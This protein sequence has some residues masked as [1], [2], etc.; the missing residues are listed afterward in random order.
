MPTPFT[1]HTA[2]VVLDIDETAGGSSVKTSAGQLYGITAGNS[3]AA[4]VYLKVVDVT[5][6][7]VGTTVPI[8]T[9][10]IPTNES[11]SVSFPGGI[12]F[13]TGIMTF[14]TVT[15]AVAAQDAPGANDC[16]AT[17]IFN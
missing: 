6:A 2:L 10:F 16:H 14:A 5:T 3:G 9:L 12:T 1:G 4:D 11:V 7:V 17:F 8:I 13:A 15:A